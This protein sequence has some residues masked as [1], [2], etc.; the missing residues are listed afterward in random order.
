MLDPKKSHKKTG[1]VIS[2][3]L[4]LG[5]L[6]LLLAACGGGGGGGGSTGQQYDYSVSLTPEKTS[7]APGGTVN[8]GL[9][10]DAP[11]SNAGITWKLVCVQSDCG[12]VTA[13]GM[14]TAPAKVDAQ[15]VVGIHATSN[16]NPNK[17][18][19]VEIWITGKIVV[20]ISPEYVGEI[21]VNKTQQFT[22][23][24]NSSDTVVTWQVNGVTGGNST[25]GTI[26]TGGLYTAPAA[27]P[28]PATVTITAIAH[29]DSTASA[30]V[31]AIISVPPPIA[32]YITPYDAS[33]NINAT[34]Q[35]SAQVVNTDD[36]AV[37]WQVNGITG[38]N[39]TLGTIS[40]T[41]LF[42]APAAVPSPAV[43]AITAVS[44]ADP[45]KSGLT[46]VS[47]INNTTQNGLLSGSY[48]F[49]ISGPD[50]AGSMRA[51]VGCLNFDGN[52]GFTST[53]DLNFTTLTGG[54]Q[55]ALQYAGTYTV[56]QDFLGTLTFNIDPAL[57]FAFTL[58]SGAKDAKLVEYDTRGTHYVGAMQKQT[59]TDFTLSK[60]AG[61]YAFELHGVTKTGEREGA[62]GRFHTD[63][64]GNIS[65][66]ALDM[67]EDG[68]DGQ[69]LS[70]LTGTAS[71]ADTTL[72][73]GTVTFAQSSTEV[74]HFSF[75]MTN[76]G[77]V[78][79]LSSDPVP[80]DNPLLIGHVLSQTGGPFSNMSLDGP[81]VF[82]L[83]GDRS[84]TSDFCL[85]VGQWTADGSTQLLSGRYDSNC[86][87]TVTITPFTFNSRFTIAADG[88]GT[89]SDLL[90]VFY[91]VGKNKAFLLQTHSGS[92]I[93]MIEPQQVS[94]FNDSLFKGTYRIGPISMPRHGADISQ[95]YL[96]AD[97]AGNLSG[98]E[99]VLGS[100]GPVSTA[101]SG[102]YSV[103]ATG[104]TIVNFTSPE[105]FRYVA[106]PVS[107]DRFIGISIQ[108]SDSLA[109]LTSLDK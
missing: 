98:A 56:G 64:Q 36:M 11:A 50:S 68:E 80:D 1:Y 95:G 79:V 66:A 16:D 18:Y 57:T 2:I 51:G 43:E 7:V 25:F 105:T 96:T 30:T 46:H 102:N 70:G 58:N 74:L 38:G 62:V 76:A 55:T 47:I 93:G 88:R 8:L 17:G 72:G 86:D 13:A 48:A 78:F 89:L 87:G 22:A 29:V 9:H 20:T 6:L 49:E 84:T 28:D 10:Y 106:Y 82:T 4:L 85:N 23:Q 45:T 94:T 21:H 99:N 5:G 67:K 53:M 101:F 42:T 26:T 24:V 71:M 31:Q 52:G 3:S 44:H 100:E 104:R 12:S 107:A 63:G 81:A 59:P 60:F 65:D 40:T 75:Y 103:D 14:Y 91:M 15:M 27:V 37:T 77:D 34:L 83:W 69:S 109:N 32:V 39:S 108:V 73:R 41:G 35:Y 97:G 54:A 90:D 19:Y 61:D 33:V 92:E